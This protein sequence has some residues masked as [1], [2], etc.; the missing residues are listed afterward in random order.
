[1]S[2]DFT[3]QDIVF[4]GDSYTDTG[5]VYDL[6]GD[7][8]LLPYPFDLLGYRQGFTNGDVWTAPLSELLGTGEAN[9]AIGGAEA[10]GEQPLLQYLALRQLTGLLTVAPDHPALQFDINLAAQVERFLNAAGDADLSGTAAWVFAGL[11]DYLNFI[12]TTQNPTP[13]DGQ[14]LVAEVIG[15]IAAQVQTLAAAGVGTIYISN[16]PSAA[17]LPF[18]ATAPPE[19]RALAEFGVAL[20]NALLD[21]AVARSVEVGVSIELVDLNR[22]SIEVV[23]DPSSFGFVAPVEAFKVVGVDDA[24]NPI[25]NPAVDGLDPDQFAFWDAVHPTAAGH[26]VIAAYQAAAVTHT[27]IAGSDSGDRLMGTV[28]RD[29]IIASGGDDS[30]VGGGGDDTILAGLGNDRVNA[31]TGDDLVLSG[32]GNDVAFGGAGNDV[33]A[34]NQGDDRLYGG[35]GN[36]VIVDGLGSDRAFGGA[37][38]DVFI[39]V[40]AALLGGAEEADRDLFVGGRGF[41]TLYMA[42][43]DAFR[44]TVEEAM[45]LGTS[46]KAAL[47]EVDID[48]RGIEAVEFVED[49]LDLAAIEVEAR[50]AEADLWGIV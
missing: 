21:G 17:F 2:Y 27:V 9:Y 7:V 13:E 49:R 44:E 11:N 31:G 24:L 10:A 45:S 12:L 3:A 29:L 37:G 20:H 42:A 32:S 22:L 41:D 50:L 38:D 33:L 23:S 34:G 47:M 14:A 28:H 35:A 43:S 25:F 48:I 16:L 36:D 4:F 1:M 30:A 39:F 18:T 26:G 5:R 40:D 19:L 15:A 46:L 6:T 8:L